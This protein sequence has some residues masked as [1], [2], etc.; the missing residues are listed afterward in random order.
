MAETWSEQQDRTLRLMYATQ[1]NAVIALMIGKT[2]P[3]VGR[4]ARKLGLRKRLRPRAWWAL[5]NK[6]RAR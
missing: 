3:Q 1:N 4:R 6:P 5:K 2:A